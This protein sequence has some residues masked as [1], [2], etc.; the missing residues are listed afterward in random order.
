MKLGFVGVPNSPIDLYYEKVKGLYCMS[1]WNQT[2]SYAMAEKSAV[3][4]L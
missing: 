1:E 4:L 2:S 3:M